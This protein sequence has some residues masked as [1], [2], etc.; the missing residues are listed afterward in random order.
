MSENS[1]YNEIFEKNS[2][3]MGLGVDVYIRILK[4]SIPQIKEDLIKLPSAIENEDFT[5]IAAIAHRIK[6]TYRNLLLNDIADLAQKIDEA[7]KSNDKQLIT[8]IAADTQS[9]SLKLQELCD[10]LDN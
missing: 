7:A 9:M 6:G 3:E 10:A 8:R 1:K 2:Q 5:S 4:T